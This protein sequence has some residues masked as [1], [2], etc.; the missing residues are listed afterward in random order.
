MTES[1]DDGVDWVG[2]W[3]QGRVRPP[4][5]GE[6]QQFQLAELAREVELLV[7]RTDEAGHTQ[8]GPA[9]E[10]IMKKYKILE[11]LQDLL[12]DKYDLEPVKAM[13]KVRPKKKDAKKVRKKPG[14]KPKKKLLAAPSGEQGGKKGLP[15]V[16][17]Q[18][19]P[20][21]PVP[22]PVG[23]DAKFVEDEEDKDESVIHN[24]L[25][26]IKGSFENQFEMDLESFGGPEEPSL[27]NSDFGIE[28]PFNFSSLDDLSKDSFNSQPVL[29][30]GVTGGSSDL[31]LGGAGK[32]DQS[33]DFINTEDFFNTGDDGELDYDRWAVC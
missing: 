8:T 17:E 25:E 18:V 2:E 29:S 9:D 28:A 15:M 10:K 19:K 21:K 14:P 20:A 24:L 6:V 30:S 11:G 1:D 32:Q 5:A 12:D 4:G 7:V 26:D 13:Q 23:A 16:E 27:S 31:L 33:L 22:K 3:E